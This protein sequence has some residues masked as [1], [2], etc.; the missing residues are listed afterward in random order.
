MKITSLFTQKI[1][2]L[3]IVEM[4]YQNLSKTGKQ[5]F[6]KILMNYKNNLFII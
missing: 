6:T 4:I 1:K 5:I 3:L 2:D